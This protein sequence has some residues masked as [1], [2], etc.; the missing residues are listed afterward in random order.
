MIMVADVVPG[1]KRFLKPLELRTVTRAMVQ[2]LVVAF[3]FHRGRMS[4]LQAAE[5]LRTDTRHRAQIGRSLQRPYFRRIDP[6]GL[7]QRLLLLREAMNGLFVFIIDATLCSQSGRLTENT[8]ST[9]N[10]KRRPRKGRRYGKQKHAKKSCHSVTAGLLITPSGVRIPFWRP[11]YTR[12][13]CRK[14]G[15]T[16]HTTAEAAAELI[17]SLPLPED[18]KVLILGDTAY[19]SAVVRKACEARQYHWIFPCNPERVLAGPKP[20]PK[21]RSRVQDW[22]SLRLQTIRLQP[23]QGP[24]VAY[25]RL[26][27]HRQGP[28]AKPRTFYVHQERRAVHSV[29][30]VCLVFSTKTSHLVKPTADDVKILM[31]NALQLSAREIVELYSLRWQIELFFKELKSGLG[32]HQYRLRQFASVESWLT[33]AFTT[34]LY[35][36]WYR[37]EQL[38]QRRLSDSHKRWW[39]QQ[40]VHGICQAIRSAS[41]KTELQYIADRIETPGGITKL[42]RLIRST[43]PSNSHASAQSVC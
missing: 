42:K 16:H 36:E 25:R 19:D 35:L 4:C 12:E 34:F 9:G 20:R 31:T 2:R 10:R 32:F 30:D 15:L 38:A 23:G 11:Y 14:K 24:Y 40:R 22:S 43:V 29:G 37:A 17:R 21:V 33:M 18:A 27:A 3:I 13:Y 7:W 39:Q 41:Q 8:F 28:Q 26:S 5:A 6:C 1:L